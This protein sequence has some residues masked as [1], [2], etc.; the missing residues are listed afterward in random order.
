MNN[1][2]TP[3]STSNITPP[4]T[5]NTTPSNTSNTNLN[6]NSNTSNIFSL[7]NVLGFICTYCCFS[8]IMVCIAIYR[9]GDIMDYFCALSCPCLYLFYIMA[10]TI[11]GCDNKYSS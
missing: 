8:L 3:S 11:R 10:N 6:S 5:G 7:N 1:N 2:T 4:N 9:C